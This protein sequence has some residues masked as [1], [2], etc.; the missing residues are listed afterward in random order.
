MG[1]RFGM[2]VITLIDTPGAYPGIGAEERGQGEAIAR[3]LRE[4][5]LLRTPVI[6]TVIGEGGSGGALALGVGD[7]VQ[8]M[9]NSIYSVISPEG[10]AAILWKSGEKA[11][12]AAEALKITAQDLLDLGV[13][14]RIVPE[15]PGG[16]HRDF[17]KAA[18]K[19]KES[20]L[21]A[22]AELKEH[23]TD[24]LLERRFEKFRKIGPYREAR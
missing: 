21:A 12:E 20:L 24:E 8:M 14:D 9:E 16:A 1:A 23:T 5:S 6:C 17:D 19:L 18:D 11:A 2:P 3:N 10:C 4:M 22:L 13:I 7:V 15:P